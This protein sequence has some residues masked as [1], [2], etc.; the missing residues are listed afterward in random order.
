MKAVLLALFLFAAPGIGLGQEIEV[1]AKD[2]RIVVLKP[3]GTWQY[4][5]P[6]PVEEAKKPEPLVQ[7][8]VVS[9]LLG[10]FD[11]KLPFD[12]STASRIPVRFDGHSVP[13]IIGVLKR[14]LAPK[15]EFETTAAYSARISSA[16]TQGILE[17]LP[18][19]AVLVVVPTYAFSEATY[20]ADKSSMSIQL[21]FFSSAGLR[22]VI[23]R[24][25]PERLSASFDIDATTAKDL[26]DNL[27]TIYLIKLKEPFFQQVDEI[28]GRAYLI[29]DLLEVWYFNTKTGKVEHKL[30]NSGPN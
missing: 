17:K 3:D 2:G 20:D 13:P 15:D 19:E 21:Q 5:I 23:F 12:D 27:G 18:L 11:N 30:K 8:S 28:L 1:L 25:T 16:K 29:A 10:T 22:D 24:N 9:N 26:K 6:K 7:N 14:R 4:K